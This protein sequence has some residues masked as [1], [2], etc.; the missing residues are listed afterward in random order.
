MKLPEIFQKRELMDLLIGDQYWHIDDFKLTLE[1]A[2]AKK[3][4][5]LPLSP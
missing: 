4:I 3:D 1:T 5:V 2:H